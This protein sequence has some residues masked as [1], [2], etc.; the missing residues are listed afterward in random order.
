MAMAISSHAL[1]RAHCVQSFATLSRKAWRSATR[2]LK[3][4]EEGGD[5]GEETDALD[6]LASA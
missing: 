5:A 2:K 1:R 3:V 4:F 6:A